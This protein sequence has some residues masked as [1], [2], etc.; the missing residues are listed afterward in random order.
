[1]FYFQFE[2]ES[3]KLM[4]VPFIGSSLVVISDKEKGKKI[5]KI[6]STLTKWP[7][8]VLLC[9]FWLL[10]NV[11][12]EVFKQLWLILHSLSMSFY[13]VSVFF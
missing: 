12:N 8:N 5:Q 3:D 13:I 9:F 2:I 1:M 11:F 6:K 7:Y 10:V 4:L